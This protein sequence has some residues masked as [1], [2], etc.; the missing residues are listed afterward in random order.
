MKIQILG[1]GC[2]KCQLLEENTKKA[3]EELG[4]KNVKVEHIYDLEK[5]IEMGVMMT[6]ALVKDGRVILAGRV[7]EVG[8]L[9]ELLK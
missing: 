6:P 9:K 2:F 4:L 7:P 5:I 1:M 3:V 8:E